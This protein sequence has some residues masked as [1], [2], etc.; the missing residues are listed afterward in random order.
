[1]MIIAGV[2]GLLQILLLPGLIVRKC[3]KIRGGVLEQ[4]LYLFPISLM[5]NYLLVY[6]CCTL[7]I[8]SQGL[9]AA[10]ILLELL[11]LIWLYWDE[12][13]QP[14]NEHV[15]RISESLKRELQPLQE[16]P[17][18]KSILSRWCCIISGALAISGIVW[19]VHLCRMNFGTVFSGWDTL[20][21]WNSYAELW[22]RGKMPKVDGMYPQLLASNWSISYILQGQDAVQFFNT[23]LP[24][25]FFLWVMLMFFDLGFQRRESGFFL[26]AFIGRFMIKKLMGDQLFD[27]YM[28]FPAAMMCMMSFYAFLKNDG[29]QGLILGILFAAGAA[30]TK[31]S[32]FLALAIAPVLAACWHRESARSM[33]RREWFL[34]I[35]A[36]LLMVFPWYARGFYLSQ[37]AGHRY[38]TIAEGVLA[39]NDTFD[40]RQKLYLSI[41]LLGKYKV[42]FLLAFVG[43]PMIPRK[44]RLP[45]V[46]L[47][48]TVTIIWVLFFTYDVRNVAVS[49]PFISLS[50]GL[51]L[52]GLG[53]LIGKIPFGKIPLAVGLILLT[54][55][56]AFALLRFLPDEKLVADNTAKQKEL[57]SEQFNRRMLYDVFGETHDGNDI[58]TDYPAQFLPGYRDCCSAAALEDRT[59]VRQALSGEKV[60]Y[61]LIPKEMPRG[62]EDNGELFDECIKDGRCKKIACS[63]DYYKSYCLYEIID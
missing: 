36:V 25:L 35:T 10:V 4:I 21:S 16:D 31:Q 15:R 8:Y 49:L 12:L 5:V 60:R 34:V 58:Y 47:S 17:A 18:R 13:R 27:G 11:A 51:A 33:T 53:M 28:D 59:Q 48:W 61:L 46:L 24:P 50:C 57:F 42:C 43:I 3:G 20:F 37:K 40:F 9:M 7:H 29:K 55:A 41:G 19:G 30:V 63:D 32:G 22:A 6:L 23:L 45:L 52:S 26:A 54:G 2:L 39:F 38:E 44:Y 62:A 56:A 14:L 1:M